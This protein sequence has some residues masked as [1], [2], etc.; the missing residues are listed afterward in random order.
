[1][2][3]TYDAIIIGAGAGGLCAAARLVNASRSVLLID[4]NERLGGRATSFEKGGSS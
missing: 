3:K 1:M 4:D 2:N